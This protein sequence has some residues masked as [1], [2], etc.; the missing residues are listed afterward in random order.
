MRTAIIILITIVIGI[1]PAGA[2]S[3]NEYFK[4][5]AEQN[6]GLQSKYKEFEAALEKV[7]QVSSLPDPVFSFGFFLSPV[8]TRVGPQ[9]CK[10]SLN[11]MFPWFGTLEAQNNA[12][13]LLAEARYQVFL[14]ARNELFYKVAAAYY[15]LYELKRWQQIEEENIEILSSYKSLASK[16][17]ENGTAAM[18]DVLRVDILIREARTELEI[19]NHKEFSLLTTFNKLLNREEETEVLIQDSIEISPFAADIVN[20]DSLLIENPVLE[21]IDLRIKAGEASETAAKKQGMPT[22]GVGLDYVIVGERNDITSPDNGKDAIMPMVSVSIPFFSKKYKAAANEARIMQESYALKKQELINSLQS[23]YES[24]RFQIKQA[25]KEI[26]LYHEQVEESRRIVNL[27]LSS[28]SSAGND[29]EEV[30]DVH[31]RLLKYDKM[32]AR[33]KVKYKTAIARMNYLIAKKY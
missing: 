32:L 17:F 7:P 23:D 16:K 27:L 15:P 22:L 13:A 4:I 33:A 25:E 18:T 5:A 2:Q 28:Y 14:D 30:L 11:Q 3:L 19:L 26:R 24:V 1:F 12:A 6:P 10:F 9:R 8:E 20:K 29:F 21:E 31:Q